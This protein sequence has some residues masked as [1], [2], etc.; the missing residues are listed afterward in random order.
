[1]LQVNIEYHVADKKGRSFRPLYDIAKDVE[2]EIWDS[3]L[4]S[5]NFYY[6]IIVEN[7]AMHSVIEY[8]DNGMKG[9]NHGKDNC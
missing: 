9:E 3:P 2:R 7:G 5:E 4:F 6:K 8:R 1:M